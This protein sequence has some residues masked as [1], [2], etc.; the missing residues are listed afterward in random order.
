MAQ[1]NKFPYRSQT[2][3]AVEFFE[4]TPDDDADLPEVPRAIYVGVSGDIAL[5]G[6]AGT[7]PVLHRSVPVG[8][9]L[10]APSRVME[11]G[12]TATGLV[13]WV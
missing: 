10:V 13:G 5:V 12:T 11:T 7:D 8:P 9:F 3:A 1:L 2:S 6:K 4:I